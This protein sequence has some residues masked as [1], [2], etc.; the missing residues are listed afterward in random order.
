MRNII[1]TKWARRKLP[2]LFVTLMLFGTVGHVA[3]ADICF[4]KG[5][6]WPNDSP[7]ALPTKVFCSAYA[8]LRTDEF[9][10]SSGGIDLDPTSVRMTIDDAGRPMVKVWMNAIVKSVEDAEKFRAG[11]S[12]YIQSLSGFEAEF[13]GY[14][15]EDE[16]TQKF[17][18]AGGVAEYS[19]GLKS[20]APPHSLVKGK[21]AFARIDSC[22]DQKNEN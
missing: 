20:E 12:R 22:E 11:T 10:F 3:M 2:V 9:P 13:K 14:V 4:P 21:V 16:Q 6:K 15:C 17:V 19:F 1:F 5:G 18:A 8:A 7:I